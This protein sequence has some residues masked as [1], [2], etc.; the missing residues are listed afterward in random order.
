MV[1][2]RSARRTGTPAFPSRLAS[3]RPVGSG[4]HYQYRR[5]V[6]RADSRRSLGLSGVVESM[7]VGAVVPLG[8]SLAQARRGIPTVPRLNDTSRAK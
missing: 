1:A 2:F 5:R 3:G 7:A 8:A 6:E 4:I